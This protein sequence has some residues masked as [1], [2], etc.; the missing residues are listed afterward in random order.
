MANTPQPRPQAQSPEPV[1]IQM[2]PQA[3][4]AKTLLG[5][6]G[7]TAGGAFGGVFLCVLALVQTGFIPKKEDV[8][9][10]DDVIAMKQ[11][12]DRIAFK[13]ESLDS[14]AMTRQE[15]QNW[16]V[17]MQRANRAKDI[18]WVIPPPHSIRQPYSYN[19]RDREPPQR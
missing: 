13:L 9:S 5:T 18:E 12:L 15:F 1:E 19:S 7:G 11:T 14:D 16:I 3:V 8:A 4:A 6:L 10:K 17:E 2:P